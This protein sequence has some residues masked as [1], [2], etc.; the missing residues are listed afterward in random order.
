MVVSGLLGFD[1][2]D[3]DSDHKERRKVK[4]MSS[5][6][7][8]QDDFIYIFGVCTGYVEYRCGKLVLLQPGSAFRTKTFSYQHFHPWTLGDIFNVNS[9]H[10]VNQSKKH[11]IQCDEM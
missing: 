4:T 1:K 11:T 8:C 5:G 2:P 9:Q 10:I 6:Y 7:Q 3:Y